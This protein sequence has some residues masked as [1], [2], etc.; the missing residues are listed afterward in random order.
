LVLKLF[1]PW[2]PR[3]LVRLHLLVQLQRGTQL[4]RRT[5]F[6]TLLYLIAVRPDSNADAKALGTTISP[7]YWHQ[8]DQKSYKWQNYLSNKC[9]TVPLSKCHQKDQKSYE[10]LNNIYDKWQ[11]SRCQTVTPKRPKILQMPK[12]VNSKITYLTNVTLSNCHT[13]KT[14]NPPNAKIA[15]MTCDKRHAVKLS[16]FHTEK[17]KNP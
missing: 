1:H 16:Y 17:T 13:K 11:M 5:G 12:L 9:H 7:V 8:K 14:K 2:V 15:Y 6:T 4:L 10:C 3:G